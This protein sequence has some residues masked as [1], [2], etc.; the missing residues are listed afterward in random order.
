MMEVEDI[1]LLL[2]FTALRWTG[3]FFFLIDRARVYL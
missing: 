1:I 2:L 3:K